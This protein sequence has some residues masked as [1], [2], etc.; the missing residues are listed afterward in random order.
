MQNL[1][2]EKGSGSRGNMSRT[3][4]SGNLGSRKNSQAAELRAENES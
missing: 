3:G 4:F 1:D 2:M